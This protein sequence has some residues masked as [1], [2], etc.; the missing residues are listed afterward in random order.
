M[1]NNNA[2]PK[3]LPALDLT[4]LY[5]LRWKRDPILEHDLK[6]IESHKTA[7]GL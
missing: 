7:P 2:G 4:T 3:A 5:E 1:V 6:L